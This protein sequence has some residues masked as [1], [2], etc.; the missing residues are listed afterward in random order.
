MVRK[1]IKSALEGLTGGD[2]DKKR[3]ALLKGTAA[4]GALATLPKGAKKLMGSVAKKL[5]K[6]LKETPAFKILQKDFFH[7]AFRAN[8]NHP[9]FA[10]ASSFLDDDDK[11]FLVDFVVFLLALFF[12]GVVF[13]LDFLDPNN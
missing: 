3:R 1:V 7:K 2:V 13:L 9:E 4:A 10:D 11:S 5:P 12:F 6:N 8:L